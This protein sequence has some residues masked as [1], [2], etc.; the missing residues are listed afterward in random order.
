MRDILFR[1]KRADNGEWVE[2]YYAVIGRKNVMIK[3]GH[4]V[5]YSV[6]ENMRKCSGNEVVEIQ[7]ETVCQY[8]GLTDKNGRKI[9]EGD[10]VR[11][12][13][14]WDENI[15]VIR[16]QNTGFSV[17]WKIRNKYSDKGISCRTDDVNQFDEVTGNIFD[18]SVRIWEES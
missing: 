9:F 1:A 14:K 17:D 7:F 5:F 6:D 4:E 16:F 2:G 10:I 18:N 3:T 8:T 11:N 13:S 12:Q 15:G